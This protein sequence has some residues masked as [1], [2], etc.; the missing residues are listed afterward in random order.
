MVMEDDSNCKVCNK[1]YN[2]DCYCPEHFAQVLNTERQK[3]AKAI[4]EDIE[5]LIPTHRNNS[6][7]DYNKL[8]K[9]W[10]VK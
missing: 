7:I 5:K 8:K 6:F 9:K 3:T 2:N 1:P 10:G 4:F